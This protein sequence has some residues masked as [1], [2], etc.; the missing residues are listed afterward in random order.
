VTQAEWLRRYAQC[1]IDVAKLTPKQAL[2]AATAEPF[3]VLSEWFE[4]DPEG[5]ADMEMSYWEE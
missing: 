2:D 1:M 4:D 5:A 3:E